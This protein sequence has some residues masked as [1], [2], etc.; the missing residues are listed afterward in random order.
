MTAVGKIFRPALRR[1]AA[2]SLVSDRIQE[3]F[4]AADRPEVVIDESCEHATKLLI[5]CR[6][7]AAR[8]QV[9][10]KLDAWLSQ[11][12]IEYAFI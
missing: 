1:Q 12:T 10:D 11:H 5:R 7:E 3:M 4:A 9:I 2:Q 6:N 8:G